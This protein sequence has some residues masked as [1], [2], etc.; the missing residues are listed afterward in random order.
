MGDPKEIFSWAVVIRHLVSLMTLKL[1]LFIDFPPK[2]FNLRTDVV[3][4]KE[5]CC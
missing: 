3:F 1:D 2:K 4:F 5:S